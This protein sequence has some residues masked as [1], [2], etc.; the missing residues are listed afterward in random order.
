M[1]K[2]QLSWW[3][4]LTGLKETGAMPYRVL[5]Y[6]KPGTGKTSWPH[7][8]YNDVESISLNEES[9]PEELIGM[10]SLR[11]GNTVFI[12]GAATRA[13]RKGV[14]LVVNEIDLASGS[15][16][17]ALHAVCDDQQIAC[18]TLPTGEVVKPADG[19]RVFATMNGHPSDLTEPLL[20]RFEVVIDCEIPHAMITDNMPSAVARVILNGYRRSQTETENKT[21]CPAVSTRRAKAYVTLINFINRDLAAHIVLGNSG[22]DFV[23]AVL[24]ATEALENSSD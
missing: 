23:N 6:G 17:A 19:F 7:M 24:A 8:N 20:D 5:L 12:D 4:I 9:A 3:E 13:F 1:E 18:V 2:N 10:W 11:D 16:E 15:V 22:P 21:W 14:P